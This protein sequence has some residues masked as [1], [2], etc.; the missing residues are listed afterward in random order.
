MKAAYESS[1]VRLKM[2]T[3]PSKYLNA[4]ATIDMHEQLFEYGNKHSEKNTNEIA[5]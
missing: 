5:S 2:H 1:V 3:M 4:Q